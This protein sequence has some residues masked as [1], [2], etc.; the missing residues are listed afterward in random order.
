MSSS[1]RPVTAADIEAAVVSRRTGTRE[2][3]AK[4]ELVSLVSRRG[5]PRW[6]LLKAVAEARTAGRDRADDDKD[7]DEALGVI[8]TL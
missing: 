5:G 4:E 6:P 1:D 3:T 7:D 8:G 2:G